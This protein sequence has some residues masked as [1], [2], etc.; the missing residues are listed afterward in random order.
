VEPDWSRAINPATS[1]AF[2][3][4]LTGDRRKRRKLE[5]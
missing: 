2:S 3:S 5:V 1:P 4:R